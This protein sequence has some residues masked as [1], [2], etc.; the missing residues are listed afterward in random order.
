MLT[1]KGAT[2]EGLAPWGW[3]RAAVLEALHLVGI[4]PQPEHVYRQVEDHFSDALPRV[5]P[6]A[7]FRSE[8]GSNLALM[9][10]HKSEGFILTRPHPYR[11]GILVGLG[12]GLLATTAALLVLLCKVYL[13]RR[14]QS[15]A[16]RAARR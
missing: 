3:L 13:E 11:P 14:A 2:L 15:S 5:S 1:H 6:T 7:D 10:Q 4:E 16:S 9:A 8:L 12:V